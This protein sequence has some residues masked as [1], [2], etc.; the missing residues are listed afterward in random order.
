[1]NTHVPCKRCV[2]AYSNKCVA[3]ILT[4]SLS[5]LQAAQHAGIPG[6]TSNTVVPQVQSPM[7]VR[8][9][10]FHAQAQQ[11]FPAPGNTAAAAQDQSNRH[12]SNE[13]AKQQQRQ[14]QQQPLGP[15]LIR[16]SSTSM[17]ALHVP[18]ASASEPSHRLPVEETAAVA[19]LR[20]P[21]QLQQGQFKPMSQE[22]W[23]HPFLSW[24]GQ[25]LQPTVPD[26]SS[27]AAIATAAS[28]HLAHSNPIVPALNVAPKPPVASWSSVFVGNQPAGLASLGASAAHHTA[29]ARA[30]SAEAGPLKMS[31]SE[32]LAE[33]AHEEPNKR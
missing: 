30:V 12:N 11:V 2:L 31:T 7:P 24:P 8:L 25:D 26:V 33:P 27:S 15:Q 29:S 9:I 18:H 32:S 3:G 20:F 16:I 22:A 13:D 6:T 5:C 28:T 10:Q 4:L 14:Q 19:P 1:M 17:S 21:G 23:P